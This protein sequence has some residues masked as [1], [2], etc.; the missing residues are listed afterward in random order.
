MSDVTTL[1]KK[2]YASSVG[3]N[4]FIKGNCTLDDIP[5]HT[6]WSVLFALLR[7]RNKYY[8]ITRD[9]EAEL[10]KNKHQ[11]IYPKPEYVFSAF[12]ITP[13]C[14]LKVV[15]LGQD[16]YF[17]S[18]YDSSSK[19][20]TPQAMGMSFSVPDDITIPSSLDNIYSNLV[21]YKHIQEKPKSGNLWF[22][23]AQGCLMLN[24]ALTVRHDDTLSHAGM[25]KW[26]TDEMIKY[27]STN[28]ENIVFVLWGGHAYSKIELI[29]Q[30]R[31]HTIISSHPSGLSCHKQFR[32]FPCFNDNDH[33]GQINARLKKYGQTPIIWG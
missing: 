21:K 17:K 28:F 27:V 12:A 15:I 10:Q 32:N 19:S 18:E 1:T 16:P 4:E 14:D 22:W 6:T 8:Q 23:A 26:M 20:M 13:A 31:H 11:Q 24:T 29:D 33:F 9:I 2:S 30:D 25:W 5:Y 3:W 7:K